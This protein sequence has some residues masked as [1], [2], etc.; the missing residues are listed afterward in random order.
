MN[1]LYIIDCIAAYKAI[2]TYILMLVL[3]HYINGMLNM[4]VIIYVK[5]IIMLCIDIYDNLNMF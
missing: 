3:L 4:H 2:Y 5:Y 1:S